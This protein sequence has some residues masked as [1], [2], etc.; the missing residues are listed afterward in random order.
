MLMIL[1]AE[2]FW[3]KSVLGRE[4]EFFSDDVLQ[5]WMSPVW[6]LDHG[7]AHIANKKKG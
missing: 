5:H 2:G 7:I 3:T 6:R 1:K 4:L